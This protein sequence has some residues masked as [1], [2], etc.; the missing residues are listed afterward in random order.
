MVT[1]PIAWE[2]RLVVW[3]QCLNMHGGVFCLILLYLIFKDNNKI[4]IEKC[5][6][7]K[8]YVIIFT[9]THTYTHKYKYV[10]F[11]FSSVNFIL[12]FMG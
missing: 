2:E 12:S 5:S 1:F 11:I 6:F 8:H 9:Y 4:E 3:M 7:I 10:C